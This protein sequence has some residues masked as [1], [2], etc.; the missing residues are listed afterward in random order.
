[1]HRID[2]RLYNALGFQLLWFACLWSPGFVALVLAILFWVGH[3]SWPLQP[4]RFAHQTL[5]LAALG[6]AVDVGYAWAGLLQFPAV[7][8]G[9]SLNLVAVWMCFATTLSLSFRWLRGRLGLA[10]VLG[11]VFGPL[12]YWGGAKLGAVSFPLGLGFTLTVYAATWSVLLP[13]LIW[14]GQRPSL[15]YELSPEVSHAR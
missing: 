9:I 15:Q 8:T 1:M 13:L 12:S 14:M 3:L 4:R 2:S 11:G 10:F 6:M 5:L 7:D